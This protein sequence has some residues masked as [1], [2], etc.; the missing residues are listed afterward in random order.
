MA[1]AQ[2]LRFLRIEIA[3]FVTLIKRFDNEYPIGKTRNNEI[4]PGD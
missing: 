2:S 3:F 1:R 4:N